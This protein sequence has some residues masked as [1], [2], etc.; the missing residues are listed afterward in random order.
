MSGSGW[1]YV[2]NDTRIGPV[3]R[4]EMERLISQ[5]SI[6]AQTMIWREGMNGWEEASGH[7]TIAATGNGPPPIAPPRPAPAAPLGGAAAATADGL[8]SGAPARGFGEAISVCF[9]KFVTFSGRA[10]RSEYWFFMLFNLLI[11]FVAGFIDGAIFGMQEEIAPISSLTSLVLFL[12]GLSVG[13]RRLHDT[14]RSGWW[15]GWFFLALIAGGFL[16]GAMMAANPYAMDDMA[17]VAAILGLGAVIYGIVL[18]VFMCQ[19]G[20]PG[21]NRFG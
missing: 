13:V 6:R 5:G 8:Y 3:E 2:E 7:F 17:A 18:L 4:A 20:D 19:K 11:S 16:I 12:P 21:P 1:Y 10:S 9:G 14:D 15:Y